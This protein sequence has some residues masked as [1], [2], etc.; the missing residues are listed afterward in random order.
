MRPPYP[1]LIMR[2]DPLPQL[3]DT[4]LRLPL[5]EAT[6]LRELIQHLPDPQAAAQELVRRGCIT[7]DQ[8]SSLF[9]D[10]QQRQT[11]QETMLVGLGDEESP[12]GADWDDWA[13][14]ICDDEEAKADVPPI[15]ESPQPDRTDDDMLP[16]ADFD[17]WNL[18]VSDDED[19]ADVPPDVELARPG[20]TDEEM[21]PE[22]ETV[23]AGIMLSGA[24]NTP[25]L[26]WDVPVP[27]VANKDKLSKPWMGW[28]GKGLLTGTVIL[29]SFFGGLHLFGA[30]STVPP[31]AIQKSREP[32]AGDPAMPVDL[33]PLPVPIINATQPD[34]V[35][36]SIVSIAQPAAPAAVAKPKSKASLYDRVR[37]IVRENKTEDTQ[38]VGMGDIAYQNVPNDG[39]IMVGMAVTYAPFFNHNIIKSVRPTYQKPDGTRYDG[40]VCGTPTGVGERVVAKEGYAIGGAAIQ[41]GMGIDGM[42]LTFMEIGADGLNPKKSYLSK[43]LGINGGSGATTYVND[44]RP[45]V[46]IAGMRSKDPNGPA[47]C[48]C[49]VTIKAG[50]LAD[51]DR[52]EMM[53]TQQQTLKGIATPPPSV[54]PVGT[55]FHERQLHPVNPHAGLDRCPLTSSSHPAPSPITHRAGTTGAA[56]GK[57][58][59]AATMVDGTTSCQTGISTPGSGGQTSGPAIP[60][61]ATLPTP[62]WSPRYRQQDRN[63][64][65]GVLCKGTRRSCKG[66]HTPSPV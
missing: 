40:P 9:P 24:A 17:D 53:Q 13:L 45:I 20:R 54:L 58:G 28:A 12:P 8:F 38:R 63:G 52:Q 56:W 34:V 65:S 66:R 5:M 32:N 61:W 48:M 11:P 10:S 19:K 22:P 36:N 43:W 33:P 31:V 18:T 16:A 2:P 14:T 39:S 47:F 55:N 1:E 15:G 42:Q 49:L 50:T 7:Q 37:K 41:A 29:G 3:I 51:A 25:R 64:R 60:C 6:Q 30:N 57:S 46:G 21:L 35:V 26:K 27:P 62:I 59:T 4:L 23:E 44:G